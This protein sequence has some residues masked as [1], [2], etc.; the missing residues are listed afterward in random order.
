VNSGRRGFGIG[1]VDRVG[2]QQGLA[3]VSGIPD[4]S[5]GIA[6]ANGEGGLD[7]ADI[8]NRRGND[9]LLLRQ[10]GDK[11]RGQDDNVRRRALA[12]FVDHDADRAKLA[13]DIE[14]GLGLEGWR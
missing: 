12:Q 9:Q 6:G 5:L 11:R 7:Q 2:G 14:A 1:H 8:G 3:Q 4:G 13:R 10:F